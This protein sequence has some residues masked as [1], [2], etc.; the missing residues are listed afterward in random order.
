LPRS[1]S[2]AARTILSWSKGS[3]PGADAG[4]VRERGHGGAY[5]RDGGRAERQQAVRQIGEAA[6]DKRPEQAAGA[7]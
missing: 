2:R 3:L 5:D 4:L 7:A 1:L 6:A